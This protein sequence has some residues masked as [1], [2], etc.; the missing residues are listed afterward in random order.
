[1]ADQRGDG[2]LDV[3]RKKVGDPFASLLGGAVRG[4]LGLE[5]ATYANDE[6]YRTAQALGNMPGVGAPAGVFKAAMQAPEALV[7]MGGLLGK[8]VGKLAKNGGKAKTETI[9]PV[10]TAEE[11]AV[12]AAFGQK[13]V[14]ESALERKVQRA[15]EDVGTEAQKAPPVT[16]KKAKRQKVEP[17]VYRKMAAEQGDD[18][19]TRAVNRGEHLKPDG[20]G[21]YIGA[22]RTV[23]SPQ[24]LGAMRR[25]LDSQFNEATKAVALADPDRLGTW[26]DRAKSGISMSA[27]PHQLDDVLDHHSVYSAGVS[28][29]GETTFSLKHLNSRMLGEPA[30]AYRGAPMKNLDDGRMSSVLVNGAE[31]DY[32]GPRLGFKIGEYRAKNDPRVPND[33]L[34]GVNDFRAAQG[35]GYTTPDG[36]IWKGGVSGTMHPFM[37]GE[38]ALTVQRANAAAVGG[39]ADWAGPHLQ[40]MPWVYGKAQDLYSRGK[41]A[42]FKG[43]ELE[44]VK[45]AIR[46]ANNTASDYFYKH[47]AAATHEAVPGASTGHVPSMLDAPFEEKLAYGRQGRWDVPSAY[48]LAD[49]PGVGAGNQDAIYSAMG[50]RQLPSVSSSGA[51]LNSAGVMEN[52]PM[53]VA[54]PLLDFPTGGGGGR[55]APLTRE[56]MN[57][58]ERYRAVIDA[59]E[60]GAWNLPVSADSVKGKNALVMDTRTTDATTGRQPTLQ[61]MQAL[62]QAVDGTGYGVTATSRGVSV[63]PFSQKATPA[64]LRKFEKARGAQLDAAFP[65]AVREKSLMSSGYV[66]GIGKFDEVGDVIPTTPYSGEAT[67]GLLS[68]FA[69]LPPNVARNIS[70]SE[71]LRDI[72]RQKIAR[73]G[74]L[75][76]ARGDIQNTRNFLAE[77]DWNRAVDMIRKGAAPAAALSALGYSA[78]SFAADE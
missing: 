66:P 48:S 28:P 63:F 40:E 62:S 55:V 69:Q 17:D 43:D 52:N 38:T 14:R 36:K 39:R 47:A 6:A 24:A 21:G 46:E 53:T 5:K 3:Y 10:R 72:I 45:A 74:G 58:A 16:A 60:A 75:L 78:S 44:G 51:Y 25:S 20:S 54:R 13:A 42:R 31:G 77:A 56:A 32:S 9:A 33:G 41:N 34:F 59:Q 68:N 2:L 7:A 57:A 65:G 22:P 49:A 12:L 4:Y 26:Y 11:Q 50:L 23:D 61:E 71:Q 73:D 64:D 19:V 18:A 67:M 1:M 27:Q 29:E 30:M 37:D 15:A 70:E 76:G 35:F 8:G